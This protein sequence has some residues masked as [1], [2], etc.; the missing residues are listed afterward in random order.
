[1][2]ILNNRLVADGAVADCGTRLLRI[3]RKLLHALF[4]KSEGRPRAAV[5]RF[6]TCHVVATLESDGHADVFAV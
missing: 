6:N 2:D 5:G 1:V 4:G 3:D